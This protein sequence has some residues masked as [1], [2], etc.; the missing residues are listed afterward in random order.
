MAFGSDLLGELH[1][2]QSQEFAI[3]AQVL[4]AIEILAS[5]TTIAAD[6]VGMSGKL[7]VIAPGAIADLLV[8]EGSPLA[9]ITVLAKPEQNF[10]MVMKAGTIYQR[11]DL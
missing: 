9:D 7:G 2:W 10:K 8:V 6:L 11:T 5:A 4:P 3:R 1:P